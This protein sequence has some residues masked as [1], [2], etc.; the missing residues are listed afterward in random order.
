MADKRITDLTAETAL[1]RVD[2]F[3]E[4]D[5]VTR[6]SEKASVENLLNRDQN[7]QTGTAYTLVLTDSQKRLT[8]NNASANAVTVPPNSSVAFPINSVL[9]VFQLGAGRTSF[10]AGAG[11]TINSLLGSLKVAGRYGHS[12]L[13]KTAADVWSLF[14]VGDAVAENLT[15]TAPININGT[16]GATTAA[17][18][19]FT[20]LT[21]S[22]DVNFDSGTFFTDVSENR[23]GIG[24]TSPGYKLDIGS[25]ASAGSINLTNN[26]Y[27]AIWALRWHRSD[28]TQVAGIRPAESADGGGMAFWTGIGAGTES[29][30]VR[31]NKSG[32]VGIGTAAPTSKLSFGAN[33]GND[34]AVYEGSGGA[35]KYGIGMGGDG[36][37]GDP[38]R[39]KLY[40]NG[41]ELISMTSAGNVGIGT[42]SPSYK[43]SLSGASTAY[44]TAPSIAFYDTVVTA[45]ARNWQIGNIAVNY[46]D[47][48]F[49]NSTAQGGVPETPRMTINAS[50]YVGIGTASP[51]AGLHLTTTTT[52]GHYLARFVVN[53]TSQPFGV[54]VQE[55]ASSASGYPLLDCMGASGA[56]YFRVNSGTG[57][58]GIGANPGTHKLQVSAA[59]T[60]FAALI[61]NST[62]SGNG[63]KINAGDNSGDRVLELNDK[64]GTSRMQVTALGSLAL[65][66]SGSEN[67]SSAIVINSSGTNF[68][69]DAGIIQGTHA[70]SGSLTGGYW[71]KFNANSADKFSVR[72]DGKVISG[73]AAQFGASLGQFNGS[74]VAIS[75][76]SGQFSIGSTN[77]AGADLGGSLGFTANTTSLTGYP[78]GNISGRLIAAGAGVYRGYMAFA[79]TDAG[80]TV[81]ERMRLTDTGL[82]IGITSPG[83]LLHVGTGSIYQNKTG[84][85]AFP[86]ISDTTSHGFMA[87]SQGANGSSIHVSRTDSAAGNFSRQ[88]TGDVLV[89]RNTS[90]SVTEAGS[91]EITGATSV[92]Y[93]TS[94]DYRLKENVVDF[95]DSID[96]VKQLNPV[97]F[98]FIGEDPVVDGFLAHEVQDIVPEAIGGEKDAMK[99]EEYEVSPAVYEDVVHP[100][101]E[102]VY[103]DVFHPATYEEVVH[104]EVEA[105]Y[106]ED[107][108]ELTPAV[109]EY[110]E[111]ILL[112]EE[113]TE[114]VLVTEAQE[115][116]TE[117][118]LVTASVKDTRSVPDYQGIDQS[119]L[120]PLLTAALQEAVAKIEALE[121]RVQT[122]EG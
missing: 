61:T 79:T 20:T 36:S 23:V 92:A 66:T 70:G 69:S 6:G 95:A 53:Q 89:F 5:H 88:G 11:V 63:L 32:N 1:T 27:E 116:R 58:V 21:A 115:E 103:E 8:M 113:Y 22:G 30:K 15:G 49:A 3:L 98:N 122:L 38:Y 35:N 55:A 107:G 45:D 85:G 50:G 48:T 73:A 109:E 67:T 4:T 87:E 47:L 40:S 64:D 120:V 34:F 43:L 81:A 39:T 31:I 118:V 46:G 37:G 78:M 93:R 18:G 84:S 57:N 121:A 14:N 76:S 108:N 68:E 111:Q 33:I 13:V 62:S 114:Q 9:P 80:G 7:N 72:G 2:T 97:R 102:A 25:S 42:T 16:V 44:S 56:T 119:K 117:S 104:P 41:T 110:S 74:N 99:D 112:T 94:S 60:D 17:A 105:T 90:S 91:I 82:G 19:A 77:T 101:V 12:V 28:N 96:R 52:A 54:N 59:T 106:D 100:A 75:N 83:A 29:E 71:L 86:G 10:V 51:S 65:T 26:T 24:T